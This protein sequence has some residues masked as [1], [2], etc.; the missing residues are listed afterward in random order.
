MVCHCESVTEAEIRHAVR[1]EWA[2]TLDD[3]R[4]R[5]RLGS[6]PCQ[7]Q[8]CTLVAACILAEELHLGS[9]ELTS[10]AME[11]LQE[12]WKGKLPVLSGLQLAHEEINRA[13]HFLSANLHELVSAKRYA[14]YGS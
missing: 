14:S 13:A 3:V 7:G 2:R 5:T 6:G 9:D 10:V 11:F 8:R 1:H 4:R 12:R